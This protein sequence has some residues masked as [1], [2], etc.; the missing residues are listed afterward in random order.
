M[1]KSTTNLTTKERGRQRLDYFL[2]SVCENG[3]DCIP[4]VQADPMHPKIDV[5][6]GNCQA[7]TYYDVCKILPNIRLIQSADAATAMSSNN[8][9][10]IVNQ[11]PAVC[12]IIT[13]W[14]KKS[15]DGPNFRHVPYTTVDPAVLYFLEQ[16]VNAEELLDPNQTSLWNQCLALEVSQG[17]INITS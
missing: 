6:R 3:C 12:P 2:Y 15:G 13:K 5:H 11:L 14:L 9:S 8:T 7:H 4:Q 17:R 16:L 1:Y 10:S